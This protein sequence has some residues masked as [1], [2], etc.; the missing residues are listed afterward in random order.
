MKVVTFAPRLFILSSFYL[1][2]FLVWGV[3]GVRRK[4]WE[5]LYNFVHSDKRLKI[6]VVFVRRQSLIPSNTK[7]CTRSIKIDYRSIEILRS[8][9]PTCTLHMLYTCTVPFFW[10]AFYQTKTI[11]YDLSSK[12]P[13]QNWIAKFDATA[14]YSA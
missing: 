10:V 6:N 4:N 14:R 9:G 8:W 1:I 2:F 7:A 12:H 13:L 3:R 5:Y 11:L